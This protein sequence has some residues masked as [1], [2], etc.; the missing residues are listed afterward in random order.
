MKLVE[1]V[2]YTAIVSVVLV[3]FWNIKHLLLF[4]IGSILIDTDHYLFYSFQFKRLSIRK[5][6]EY[7][8]EWLP[9]VKHKIPYGGICI[10]HTV[11][12]FFL[13]AIAAIKM[14]MLVYLLMGMLFH[15][16]LDSISLY[17]NQCLFSRAYSIVEHLIRSKKY[18][19]DGYPLYDAILQDHEKF[20]F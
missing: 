16:I 10:F 11:E 12:I 3:F 20:E 17:Q 13:V 7:Y 15:F 4:I 14:H 9:R 8:T 1:H 19:K 2:K 18:E 5:M 6:F